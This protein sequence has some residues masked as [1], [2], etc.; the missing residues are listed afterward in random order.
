MLASGISIRQWVCLSTG[1]RSPVI[2]VVPLLG[3]ECLG[4]RLLLFLGRCKQWYQLLYL[5]SGTRFL[6]LRVQCRNPSPGATW[7]P[8][9]QHLDRPSHSLF[10]PR[11]PNSDCGIV[12]LH[13]PSPHPLTASL[14]PPSPSPPSLS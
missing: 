8:V 1:E 11:Y 14:S 3:A 10:M 2:S 7:A 12:N 5:A 6:I 13:L 4:R 9:V